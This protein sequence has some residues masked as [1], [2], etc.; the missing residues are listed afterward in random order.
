MSLGWNVLQDVT[1]ILK[2]EKYAVSILTEDQ[3]VIFSGPLWKQKRE[4]NLK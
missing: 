4:V 2:S 3:V 1:K